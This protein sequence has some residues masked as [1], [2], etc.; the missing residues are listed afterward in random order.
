MLHV[1]SRSIHSFFS[2]SVDCVGSL[3]IALSGCIMYTV[4]DVQ[5]GVL[6]GFCL[7]WI[8]LIFI[9]VFV[10]DAGVIVFFYVTLFRLTVYLARETD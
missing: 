3:L 10:S 8:F 1:T 9:S 7:L 2:C 5:Y 4:V 6:C